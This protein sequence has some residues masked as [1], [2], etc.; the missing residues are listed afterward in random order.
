MAQT[1]AAAAAETPLLSCYELAPPGTVAREATAVAALVRR[2]LGVPDSDRHLVSISPY[3]GWIHYQDRERLWRN[4][5]VA[6]VNGPA[7]MRVAEERVTLLLRALSD[8]A[9][10]PE[11]LRR[12]A[13]A[14]AQLRPAGA[15]VLVNDGGYD[16]WLCRFEPMLGLGNGEPIAPVIGAAV[17]VRLAD[18]GTVI[19]V[20]MRWRALTSCVVRSPRQAPVPRLL[21][22][23]HGGQHAVGDRGHAP[24][25]P[26]AHAGPGG[27]VPNGAASAQK[28]ALVF[29]LEGE[30]VPQLYLTPFYRRLGGHAMSFASAC[31]LSLTVDLWGHMVP[32][33]MRLRA[34]AMGGSG[35]YAY[36]W[37][38]APIENPFALQRH[39]G[40]STAADGID[41]AVTSAITVPVGA[42]LVVIQVRDERSGGFQHFQ[43][44]VFCSALT[45]DGEAVEL[46]AEV[47]P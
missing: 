28:D 43:Q 31:P 35:R 40:G 46:E 23:D 17:D 38:V 30:G 8:Q 1:S 18:F 20:S 19:G 13:L 12:L 9:Q 15:S 34:F 21:G 39:G 4:R 22:H 6:I 27:A 44:Q 42:H 26:S 47:M 24:G 45:T 33:G 7:A 32:G 25:D 29:V 11:S 14:P 5:E 3:S 36:E 2:V 41:G 16:H 37:A 10:L